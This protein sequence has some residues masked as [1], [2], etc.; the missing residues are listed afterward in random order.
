MRVSWVTAQIVI[1]DEACPVSDSSFYRNDNQRE[2][3]QDNRCIQHHTQKASHFEHLSILAFL[4]TPFA[5]NLPMLSDDARMD[6]APAAPFGDH[7]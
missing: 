7:L 3:E 5:R 6:T 4:T 1:A 2:A